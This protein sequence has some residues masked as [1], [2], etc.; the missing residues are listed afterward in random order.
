MN[1]VEIAGT[2]ANIAA[3]LEI[4]GESIYTVR[5]YQRIARTVNRLPTEL[6]QMVREGR[7]LR[8]IP[9][10]GEAIAGKIKAML[11]TGGLEY[12]ERLRGQFP[13]GIPDLIR[14]PGLGPKTTT[15]LWRELGV[16]TVSGLEKAI[17]DGRTAAL[18]RMGKKSADKILQHIRAG[19]RVSGQAAPVRERGTTGEGD[20]GQI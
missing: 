13:A 14:I 10:V 2:F 7:D 4:K 19:R 3:L 17:T 6:D 11:S 5:A 18:P 15:R 1:N 16:T 20:T 8:E 9:G 12:Y